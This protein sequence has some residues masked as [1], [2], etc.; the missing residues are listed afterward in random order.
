MST[1]ATAPRTTRRWSS[2]GFGSSAT[3]TANTRA[4]PRRIADL[5]VVR[6]CPSAGDTT[7]DAGD[8]RSSQHWV[9]LAPDPHA[10]KRAPAHV[11]ALARRLGVDTTVAW[12][13]LDGTYG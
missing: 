7:S 12:A 8:A 5:L 13:A 4:R 9:V 11:S 10:G 3:N 1:Y 2:N 6:D